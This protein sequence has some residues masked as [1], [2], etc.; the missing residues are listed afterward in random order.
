M[1]RGI[2]LHKYWKISFLSFKKGAIFNQEW[3]IMISLIIIILLYCETLVLLFMSVSTIKILT[4][5]RDNSIIIIIQKVSVVWIQ[6]FLWWSL[7]EDGTVIFQNLLLFHF[8]W[9]VNSTQYYY[10]LLCYV[11][12]SLTSLWREMKNE[13]VP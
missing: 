1:N 10:R 3:M 8:I 6:W 11:S 13:F 7:Y 4:F 12:L 2:L 9:K 5:L